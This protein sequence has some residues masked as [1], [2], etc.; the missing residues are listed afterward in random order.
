MKREVLTAVNARASAEGDSAVLTVLQEG[1]TVVIQGTDG[2]H[3]MVETEKG[4]GYVARKYII[5]EL[6]LS[7][8]HPPFEA[9]SLEGID[10]DKPMV[11]LTFDDGPKAE[12]TNRV[13]AAL[14][15]YGARATF[16]LM[17]SNVTGENND[18]VRKM[19]AMGCELGN[20]T[21]NHT[22][23]N[24]QPLSEIRPSVREGDYMIEETC[25]ILPKTVRPPGGGISEEASAELRELGLPA[26]FWSI[27]TLDWQTKDPDNTY[28][29]VM[30]EVRDGD[31][32]LMH[33]VHQE[34]ADAAERIIPALLEKGYQLVTVSEL[35]AARGKTL[36]AG[37]SY[38]EFWK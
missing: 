11:A 35:A 37:A 38:R 29:V 21:Y 16:Y 26:I 30:E 2:T 32:I 7:G 33:D 27:D 36:E 12:S 34:T 19:V 10:P 31:I 4:S 28:R 6:Y 9:P 23:F 18:C 24:L 8:N 3:F 20:H 25:G 5:P 14:E 13:L 22:Y 15:K 1:E 17:G